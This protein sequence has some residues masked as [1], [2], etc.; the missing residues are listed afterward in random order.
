MNKQIKKWKANMKKSILYIIL[1]I[2]VFLVLFSQYE[3]PKMNFANYE[4][5]HRGYFNEKI[6]ENSIESIKKAIDL[7]KGI[8]IDIRLSKDEKPMVFHDYRLD[9]MTLVEGFLGSFTKKELETIKLIGSDHAIPSLNEALAIIDGEVPLILDLKGDII[10]NRLE[11]KVLNALVDYEGTVYLQ[12]ANPLTNHY[13]SENSSYKIGY[14]TISIAPFGDIFFQKVQAL[15]A[16]IISEFDY[17]ALNGKYMQNHE[18]KTLDKYLIWFVNKNKMIK[19]K[20]INN[21]I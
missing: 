5:A 17:V 7:N 20:I 10:S 1:T 8:E 11:E 15:F 21:T 9:R 16:D 3:L 14:I 18:L 13:L 4:Y 6:P 19:P 12:S 2:I